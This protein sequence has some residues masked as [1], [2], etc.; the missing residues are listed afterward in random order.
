[1]S[2]T[3]GI[4]GIGTVITICDGDWAK[5]QMDTGKCVR[6]GIWKPDTFIWNNKSK[7]K[8]L[9]SNGA[10]YEPI[11]REFIEKRHLKGFHISTHICKWTGK[12][13][14]V[15]WIINAVDMKAT[16]WVVYEP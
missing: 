2:K 8:A 9:R 15:G 12:G 5:E 6:R 10:L 16:D 1:M 7:Y 3:I 14:A 11:N 4:T 13:I